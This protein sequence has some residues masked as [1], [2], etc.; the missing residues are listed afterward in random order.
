MCRRFTRPGEP[1]KVVLNYAEG[2][3]GTLSGRGVA[4]WRV[5][6]MDVAPG[7]APRSALSGLMTALCNHTQALSHTHAHNA[8]EGETKG[9]AGEP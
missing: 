2:G 1:G 4:L 6:R 3:S 9:Q 5:Q 7:C 8:Q